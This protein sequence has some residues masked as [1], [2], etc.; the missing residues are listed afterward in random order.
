MSQ[1]TLI[2]L[3]VFLGLNALVALLTWLHCRKSARATNDTK[4]YFLANSGLNWVF[5]AG[6]ITLTMSGFPASGT[7]AA[8]ILEATNAGLATITYPTG[9]KWAGGTAPALTS[10][11]KDVLGY[12]SH[13]G[14]TTI[15]WFVLG[16]DVK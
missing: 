14:G 7:V 3:G 16:K 2:Q 4:E 11:G 12:Y 10:A 15:N 6:S 5:I 1:S 9:S 13:D 8:G